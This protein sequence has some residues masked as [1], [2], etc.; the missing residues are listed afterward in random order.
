[1]KDS[2][3]Q[4][5]NGEFFTF[6]KVP[7]TGVI[8]V[9]SEAGECGYH[10]EPDQWVNF[11]QGQPE[12]GDIPGAPPRLTSVALNEINNE[13]GPVAGTSDLKE[14]V[15]DF[16]NRTYR[17]GQSSKYGPENV[18]ISPGGRA[19][20][21]RVAAALGNL[22]LG[23][24]L[25][26]YTAYEELLGSFKSFTSI[27][28]LL[29]PERQYEFSLKELR[30]EIGGRGLGGLLL[31]NPCNPTGKLIS[32][33]EL[34]G[35]VN[36]CRN[37]KCMLIVDE[38]YSRYIWDPVLA[39]KTNPQVSA[40]EYVKDVNRDP[41]LLIDGL[42]KNWRYPGWRVSW[43][44]GPEKVIEAISSAGSFLDGGASHPMQTAALSL[45]NHEHCQME[46]KAIQSHFSKKRQLLLNGLADLGVEVELEPQG[47]FYIWGNLRNLPPQ[48][49]NS[50]DFFK[51]GLQEKIIT[52]PGEF[53]DVNPGRRRYGRPSRFKHHTRFSFG[54]SAE[55]IQEG[56][57]KIKKM[58]QHY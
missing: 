16:Y 14:A 35:W 34:E 55:E 39:H 13:Y 48:I 27:P 43:T 3:N 17:K 30:K 20:L 42:T 33:E 51:A 12:A 22:N 57:R 50:M 6:R 18:A 36:I 58:I 31:S 56:L 19:G 10:K 38:F 40:A 15:A 25:P 8:Y 23:H 2:E 52:V 41:V 29:E 46:T 37:M 47:T 54:P 26:D 45:M 44:V 32:G 5:S 7:R 9:M 4:W 1:M 21:T 53:F 11:G 28:I 24:F 49:S